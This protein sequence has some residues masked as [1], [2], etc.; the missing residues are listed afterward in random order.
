MDA[1]LVET[2]RQFIPLAD[3]EQLE[4]GDSLSTSPSSLLQVSI[5]VVSPGTRVP[6]PFPCETIEHRPTA[7]DPATAPADN[8]QQRLQPPQ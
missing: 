3:V 7:P 8:A 2:G 5:E 4:P 1:R 6:A